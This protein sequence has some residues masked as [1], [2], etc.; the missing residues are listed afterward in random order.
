MATYWCVTS[1]FFDNGRTL[2]AITG[3]VEADIKPKNTY[4]EL[5]DRDVY[6]DWFNNIKEANEHVKEVS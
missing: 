3:T 5:R 1:V 6:T 2:A 4:T